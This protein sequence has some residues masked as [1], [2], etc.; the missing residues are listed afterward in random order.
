M[1]EPI[2]TPC[3]KVCVIDPRS[4]LCIGC[5]RTIEEIAGWTAMDHQARVLVMASLPERLKVMTSRAV[6]QGGGHAR[7]V[8]R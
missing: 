7:T 5:G 8:S 2:L 4:G 1:N 3:K 6:R